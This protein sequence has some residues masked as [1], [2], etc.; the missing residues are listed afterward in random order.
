MKQIK[1]L[2]FYAI[3]FKSFAKIIL[4][5]GAM[6]CVLSG[7]AQFVKSG[8]ISIFSLEIG[9]VNIFFSALLL[10]ILRYL[11]GFVEIPAM[12]IAW[13]AKNDNLEDKLVKYWKNI[14][15]IVAIIT[16]LLLILSPVYL[17][18]Y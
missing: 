14:A 7:L 16:I 17:V 13:I 2:D 18:F 15:I 9:F 10:A 3:R 12:I 11:H 1:L 8:S 5:I 4:G 6:S